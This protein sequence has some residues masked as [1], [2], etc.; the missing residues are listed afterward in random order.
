MNGL[1]ALLF[2]L[3]I[4]FVLINL[5]IR[6]VVRRS[7]RRREGIQEDRPRAQAPGSDYQESIGVEEGE[8]WIPTGPGE[9][10]TAG[11]E[12]VV[13]QEP[14]PVDVAAEPKEM[15]FPRQVER[16]KPGVSEGEV[17]AAMAKEDTVKRE[18][19]TEME[20]R[21]KVW[22][23]QRLEEL[24][25][26]IEVIHRGEKREA[27]FWERIERLPSLQ[28]AIVLSEVLGPPKGKEGAE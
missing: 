26:T 5:L 25:G 23:K 27:S 17:P 2:A 1:E 8:I 4:V 24:E 3:F 20:D 11:A 16:V 7:R 28:R 9:A 6:F 19:G 12:R 18:I 14:A 22:A 13:Q 21:S 15:L 10:A